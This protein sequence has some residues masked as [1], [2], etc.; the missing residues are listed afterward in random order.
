MQLVLANQSGSGFS[1]PLVSCEGGKSYT[2]SFT[3]KD[4]QD[5]SPSSTSYIR[6][7]GNGFTGT[8]TISDVQIK[9]EN[10]KTRW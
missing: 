10:Y 8:L 6:F 7:V 3:T 4:F 5:I 1:T 9:P 2:V